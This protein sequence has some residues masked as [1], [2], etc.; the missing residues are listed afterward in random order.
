MLSLSDKYGSL[1]EQER[2][3]ECGVYNLLQKVQL[4]VQLDTAT[5]ND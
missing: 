4:I 5:F 3:N 1:P 2:E